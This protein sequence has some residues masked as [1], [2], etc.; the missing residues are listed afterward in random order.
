[1]QMLSG[2]GNHLASPIGPITHGA[3]A[4]SP[5]PIYSAAPNPM[6]A[7]GAAAGGI[8]H[9]AFNLLSIIHA[10]LGNHAPL[11]G[12]VPHGFGPMGAITGAASGLGGPVNLPAPH[13]T[14]GPAPAGVAPP[15]GGYDAHNPAV[16]YREHGQP[17]YA[18]QVWESRH[19]YA[20]AHHQIPG[21]VGQ[22]LAHALAN[23][24]PAAPPSAPAVQVQ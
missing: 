20:M 8:P 9:S 7:V 14:P 19:P 10:L 16:Y 13:I 24:A 21:W 1:M 15:P 4:G 17:E 22:A 12:G 23:A 11:P 18:A 3:P 2:I 5:G 6:G